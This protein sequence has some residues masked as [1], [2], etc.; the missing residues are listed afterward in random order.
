MA[1]ASVARP[2]RRQSLVG[3]TWIYAVILLLAAIVL[4]PLIYVVIGGFRTTGDLANDPVALPHPWV[5]S[6]YTAVLTD[7]AF[8]QSVL[9]SAVIA[10]ITT[11]VVVGLGSLAAF[12]LARYEFR[13]RELVYVIFTVG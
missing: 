2:R 7:S 9:N 8:W 1:A 4:V 12:A 3:R 5:K 13:G 10:A 11:V 6:N